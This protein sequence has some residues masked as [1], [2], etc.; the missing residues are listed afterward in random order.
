M[1]IQ[2]DKIINRLYR[3]KDSFAL[4]MTQNSPSFLYTPSFS[5]SCDQSLSN[6][7]I[8]TEIMFTDTISNEVKL[9]K[10]KTLLLIN[11]TIK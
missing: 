1:L 5:A 8:Q 7:I 4:P 9:R 11:C 2:N 10:L 3:N 6:E